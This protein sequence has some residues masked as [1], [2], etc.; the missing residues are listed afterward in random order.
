MYP[1]TMHVDILSASGAANHLVYAAERPASWR[2]AGPGVGNAKK[3]HRQRSVLSVLAA[4][5]TVGFGGQIGLFSQIASDLIGL[6]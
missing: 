4:I 2:T 3:S 5:E 6:D 1:S